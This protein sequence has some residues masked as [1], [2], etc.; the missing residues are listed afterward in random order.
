MTVLDDHEV[1]RKFDP[2]DMMGRIGGLPQQ[3][4]E[5]WES[6]LG[7]PLPPDYA[8]VDK[9]VILGMGGSAIGGDLVRTLALTQGGVPVLVH[10]DYGLPHQVDARTLVIA[11]SYSGNTEETLSSFN[12]ALKTPAKKVAITTGGRLKTLAEERVLPVLAIQYKAEPRVAFGYSLFSLLGLLQK[13]GL[14]SIEAKDMGEM[15]GILEGL[16]AGLGDRVS[17]ETNPAKQLATRLLGRLVII[18]G[19]GL[20]SKVAFRWKTQFNEN[21]KTCAFSES[22]PELNHNAVVGYRFPAWLAEKAFVILLRSP[23][24]H[25]RILIRYDITGELLADAGIAHEVVDAS[26]ES[27]LAQIMSA[28]L[29]GDYVSYYLALLNEVDPSP[30]AA[31]DYLKG[32]LAEFKM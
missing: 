13:L 2:S 27:P 31:I 21:G 11:S 10:R 7:F 25:P 9:V 8:A 32:R 20:L 28:V 4:L 17:Q 18:Y 14:I 30:V 6:A 29:L 22:I 15:I 16:S 19:A 24:L 26:G 5:A 3:C 23:S 12:Q 1:Y